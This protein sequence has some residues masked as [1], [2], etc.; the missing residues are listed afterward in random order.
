MIEHDRDDNREMPP[1]RQ[2]Q[3]AAAL[4]IEKNSLASGRKYPLT[5]T[6]G[7]GVPPTCQIATHSFHYI[8][9]V[10]SDGHNQAGERYSRLPSHSWLKKPHDIILVHFR[11]PS[12]PYELVGSYLYT[13]LQNEPGCRKHGCRILHPE[14]RVRI[15]ELIFCLSSFLPLKMATIS[16]IQANHESD[17]GMRTGRIIMLQ[18]R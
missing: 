7:G 12:P 5:W 8:S 18:T 3:A 1:C 9:A 2:W 4:L 11:W 14:C 16:P 15:G 17:T 6:R 13:L 10:P